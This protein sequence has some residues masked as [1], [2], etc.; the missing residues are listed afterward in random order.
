MIKDLNCSSSEAVLGLTTYV[1]AFGLAPLFTS[2]FSEEFGR[3][4]MYWG[5]VIV[6]LAMHPMIALCVFSYYL[7]SVECD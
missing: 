2:A 3:Q 4:P 5:S 7:K 1:V 6:F